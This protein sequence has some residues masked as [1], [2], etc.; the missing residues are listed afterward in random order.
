[1]IR[2]AAELGAGAAPRGGDADGGGAAA[3]VP[4]PPPPPPPRRRDS[5]WEV[6]ADIEQAEATYERST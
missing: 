4:P 6:L 3:R 5:W 1:M 2:R